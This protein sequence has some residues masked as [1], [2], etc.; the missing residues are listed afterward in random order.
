MAIPKNEWYTIKSGD[1]LSKIARGRHLLLEKHLQ[2][3]AECRLPEE[4]A[5]SR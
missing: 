1:T 2:R 3:P 5:R 4:A